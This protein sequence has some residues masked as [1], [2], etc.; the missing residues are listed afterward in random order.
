MFLYTVRERG[1]DILYISVDESQMS[2]FFLD[3]FRFCMNDIEYNVVLNKPDL[4]TY[5]YEIWKR[6]N[7][8][9][10]LMKRVTLSLD[11]FKEYY[12]ADE[13]ATNYRIINKVI[14]PAIKKM[15]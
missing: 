4:D 13:Q 2:V 8:E 5:E 12:Y 7:R 15:R 3:C 9:M 1:V 14:V 10:S 6:D 11:E